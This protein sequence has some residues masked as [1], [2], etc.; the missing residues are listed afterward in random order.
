MSRK[1]VLVLGGCPAFHHDFL[2]FFLW[3]VSASTLLE[4]YRDEMLCF[5]DDIQ[6]TGAT[7]L[8]G[9][10]S[11]IQVQEPKLPLSQQR[12]VVCGAGSAGMGVAAAIRSAMIDEGASPEEASAR[13]WVLTEHGLL[14]HDEEV[15]TASQRPF[16]RH[17]KPSGASLLSVVKDVKPTVLLG[18]TCVLVFVLCFVLFC[19]LHVFIHC[20]SGVPG[21]FSEEVVRE[22]AAHCAKPIV[23]PMSNPTSKAE[24]TAQQACVVPCGAFVAAALLT[25]FVFPACADLT[26]P[27]ANAYLR[28]GR[29]LSPSST[30][31]GRTPSAKPTTC[32]FSRVSAWRPAT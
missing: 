16:Q 18:L 7:A 25:R 12:I 28:R 20:V 1:C 29:R 10:M 24:C 9:L 15:V 19:L 5:N 23:F 2:V 14:G 11:A 3:C 22:M 30:A 6:G 21:V 8:A 4:T 27:T 32:T 26:G 17:D 13:F 31:T